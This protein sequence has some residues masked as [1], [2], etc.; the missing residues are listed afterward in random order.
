LLTPHT[1]KGRRGPRPERYHQAVLLTRLY[2]WSHPHPT[3]Q[4]IHIENT[5]FRT[6]IFTIP[7]HKSRQPFLLNSPHPTISPTLRMWAKIR[8]HQTMSP[9]PSPL[10]P[11][12]HN[13]LFQP[14]EDGRA[15]KQYH[16][17]HYLHL[18]EVVDDT[19]T[20]VKPLQTTTGG[21]TVLQT[22]QYK[23]LPTHRAIGT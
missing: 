8:T 4:W 14:G 22:F 1:T 6:P 12:T 5:F 10:Y 16:D 20:Q 17:S 19:G 18:A 15:F 3:A 11:I 21:H 2:D 13:P 23:Q 9:Y 7:W